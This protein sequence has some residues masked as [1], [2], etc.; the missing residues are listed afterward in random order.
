[1][2]LKYDLVPNEDKNKLPYLD[3]KLNIIDEKECEFIDRKLSSRRALELLESKKLQTMP[4]NAKT[5]CYI[6]KTLFQD[7]Y[8]W[9]GTFRSCNITKGN[10]TFFN[11]DFLKFGIEE[12][13]NNLNKDNFLE[14]LTRTEFVELFSYYSNEM[15]FL[16]PFREGNG[17]T[18]KIFL[19][20]LARRAGYIIDYTKITHDKLR[21]AEIKA[22]GY[23]LDDGTIM[24]SI[25]AL[26]DLYDEN[27]VTLG[28]KF[29]PQID[30]VEELIN[31]ILW[32]YDRESQVNWMSCHD[33]MHSGESDVKVLLQ[34]KEGRE[35]LVVYLNHARSGVKPQKV[36]DKIDSILSKLTHTKSKLND[37]KCLEL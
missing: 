16:H 31:R 35:K 10:N 29:K 24:H 36:V 9:A 32:I 13:F 37:E 23:S 30:T 3:N 6:H 34:T 14:N 25:Y 21:S 22:F 11:I 4:L 1:M 12:F 33:N 2:L 26:K 27:I 17:R 18:K 19:T 20:E 5:L 8:P 28:K 15:N 7:I